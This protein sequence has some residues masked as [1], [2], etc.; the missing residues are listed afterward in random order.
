[1]VSFIVVNCGGAALLCEAWY[2]EVC[3]DVVC[4]GRVAIIARGVITR[5][6]MANVQLR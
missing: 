3:L 6:V 4:C 2:G 1:M 5:F